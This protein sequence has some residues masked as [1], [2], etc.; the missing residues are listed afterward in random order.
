[1]LRLLRNV[2]Q[3]SVSGGRTAV[4]GAMATSI[5]FGSYEPTRNKPVSISFCHMT[6]LRDHFNGND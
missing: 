3:L 5:N 2:K 4:R 1:M 6:S